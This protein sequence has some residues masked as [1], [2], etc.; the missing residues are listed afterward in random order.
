MTRIRPS[1][2]ARVAFLAAAAM[3]VGI[4]IASVVAFT[5]FKAQL[6]NQIDQAL[7]SQAMQ[8]AHDPMLR[9]GD[10]R[11]RD[12]LHGMG[13]GVALVS[14][15]GQV[16]EPA[17]TT[18][19][20]PVNQADVRQV[21]QAGG[22]RPILRDAV[23]DGV[24][25][26][27]VTVGGVDMKAVVVARSLTGLDHTISRLELTILLAALGLAV[28]AATAG[29]LVARAGLSPVR[30]LTAAAARIARTKD[31][32]TPIEVTGH[33]ELA[34][35]ATSFNAMLAALNTSVEQQRRLVSDAGHELRTPLTSLRANIDLLIQSRRHPDRPLPRGFDALLA[36]VK[37][38]LVELT[39][40]VNDLVELAR[41]HEA[42]RR[43]APVRFDLVV[44]HAVERVQRRGPETAFE[45][46]VE[47]WIVRGYE[48]ELA[49]AV[50]NL[51]DN[52]VKFGPRGG[53]VHVTLTGG[54][55]TVADDGV[56]IAPA[57]LPHVFERFYRSV[58]A[59]AVPGAGLGLPIVQ[60][61]A[62]QHGGT[63]TAANR[64]GGGA[65]L[66]LRLPGAP[67]PTA[68]AR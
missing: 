38:Q 12:L 60:H 20:V 46:R 19:H 55:L 40:L 31:L 47:P 48:A 37:A 36:D 33:D 56:G 59:R 15:D 54:E 7:I 64:P 10:E 17:G 29:A 67:A 18:P 2:R 68:V 61:A 9:P 30:R 34:E 32:T 4:G 65:E 11:D 50:T 27:V 62:Q 24:H 3:I 52:A 16:S 25:L 42:G 58:E 44:R 51:L 66:K 26:R 35:L 23:S 5:V 22:M 8:L 39:T 53:T 28:P 41:E 6:R 21:L 63:V 49:R 1:L 13:V 57:D 45:V 14:A 43:P